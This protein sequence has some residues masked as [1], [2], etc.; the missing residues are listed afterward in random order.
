[1]SPVRRL[2]P[3]ILLLPMVAACGSSKS[4]DGQGIAAASKRTVASGTA[5]FSLV[6]RGKVA[7]VL[8]RSSDTGALSF[9]ERKAHFY[10]LVPGGGLPQEIVLDGPY[11]YTNAN[12]DK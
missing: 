9:S 3:I 10:K 6:V 11:A 2:L 7:G 5:S 12:V 1:M 8:V 4:A